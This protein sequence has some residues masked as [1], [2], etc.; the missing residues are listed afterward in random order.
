MDQCGLSTDCALAAGAQS[1]STPQ[2]NGSA[3]V[4]RGVVVR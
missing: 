1:T 2:M 4:A 3:L